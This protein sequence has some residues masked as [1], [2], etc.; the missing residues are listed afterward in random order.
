MSFSEHQNDGLNQNQA[1]LN[2]IQ[3]KKKIKYT[4]FLGELKIRDREPF[5][6]L[7]SLCKNVSNT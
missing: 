5:S 6:C 4:R 7:K 1:K 3:I 2:E